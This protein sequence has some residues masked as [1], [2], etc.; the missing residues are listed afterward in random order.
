MMQKIPTRMKINSFLV[1][2]K[3]MTKRRTTIK[4]ELP[5]Q[6]MHRMLFDDELPFRPRVEKN[7][8]TTFKRKPKHPNKGDYDA[9]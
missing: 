1:Y 6:R 4:L 9:L 8:K 2:N 7:P 5:K 3:N